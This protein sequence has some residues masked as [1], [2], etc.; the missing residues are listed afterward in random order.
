VAALVG[1][2]QA[3]TAFTTANL[4]NGAAVALFAYFFL[5]L[6]KSKLGVSPKGVLPKWACILSG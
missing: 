1:V 2:L 5:L 3:K 4:V 6:R